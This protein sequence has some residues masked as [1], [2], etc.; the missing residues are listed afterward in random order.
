MR[1]SAINGS[2]QSLMN[3][4]KPNILKKKVYFCLSGLLIIALSSIWLSSASAGPF[5]ADLK[6]F[7]LNEL[8]Y[9]NLPPSGEKVD[10]LYVLGGSQ[11]SLELKF[12]TAAEILDS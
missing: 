9:I 1:I 8:I 3:S 5:R 11:P 7:I 10:A 4:S 2:Y 6:Q 12:N